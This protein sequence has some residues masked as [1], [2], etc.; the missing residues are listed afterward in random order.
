MSPNLPPL[1]IALEM[2]AKRHVAWIK[3]PLHL[4]DF[5][6]KFPS[7]HRKGIL[8]RLRPHLPFDP[9]PKGGL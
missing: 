5:L 2:S 7:S 1:P 3:N 8:E 6:K 9:T 4:Q